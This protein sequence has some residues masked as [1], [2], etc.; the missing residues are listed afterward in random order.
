MKYS[1]KKAAATLSLTLILAGCGTAEETDNG[2]INRGESQ[3]KSVAIFEIGKDIPALELEKTAISS[4]EYI[5][6]VSPEINGEVRD[7]KVEVGDIV[8]TGATLISLGDSLSTDQIDLQYQTS[9]KAAQLSEESKNTTQYSGEQTIQAAQLGMISAEKSYNTAV[10]NKENTV[11]LFSDQY[12]NAQIAIDNAKLSY[13]NSRD[14][15]RDLEDLLDDTKDQLYD[16][17]DQ[18]DPA[19]DATEKQ[20]KSSIA[21]LETQVRNAELGVDIANNGI[22]QAELALDQLA[23]NYRSQFTQLN[24]AITQSEIQYQSAVN[25]YEQAQ[26]GAKLQAIGAESQALQSRSAAQS[27]TLNENSKNIKAPIAGRITEINTSIGNLV[28]PGQVLIK[29]ENDQI[30]SVRTSVN[31]SEAKFIVLGDEVRIEYQGAKIKGNIVSISPT[32]DEVSKKVD[33]EIELPKSAQLATGDFVKVYFN[34]HPVRTYFVPI[35]SIFIEDNQKFVRTVENGK[36]KFASVEI[37]EI[38]G[39]YAE[40]LTGIKKGD[41]VIS[42]VES[43]LEEGEKVTTK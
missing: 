10:T 16:I 32:L 21:S 43:F 18:N 34:I 7:I 13:A 24:S 39:E 14:N 31:A 40:V 26:A 29:I 19:L 9:Q 37:G 12:E 42:T 38:F 15:L 17:Q 23:D 6:K 30:I 35:N 8:Q 36:V 5:A 2:K 27:A 22:K 11:K 25:Q 3:A 41:K 4:A 20:L 28:S 1:L 33:I